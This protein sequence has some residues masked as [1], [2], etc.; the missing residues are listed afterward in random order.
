MAL[1]HGRLRR[2]SSSDGERWRE[3]KEYDASSHDRTRVACR[4][5]FRSDRYLEQPRPTR[6]KVRALGDL[7][8]NTTRNEF[9]N[10]GRKTLYYVQAKI[11]PARVSAHTLAAMPKRTITLPLRAT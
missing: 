7:H 4:Q 11:G 6:M 1:G 2:P 10:N 9:Q 5:R 3:R 8:M